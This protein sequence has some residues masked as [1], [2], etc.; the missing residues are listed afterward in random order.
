[1]ALYEML[2]SGVTTYVD[3]SPMRPNWITEIDAIGIRAC[4]APQY[5]SAFWYT[6]NG[7]EVLYEWDE[8]A[9]QRTFEEAL[10]LLDDVRKQ[11]STRITGM[12]APG[13]IDTCTPELI[14]ASRNAA[15]ERG[16]PWQIHAAQSVVEFREMFRRHGKTPIAWLDHLG[17][18]GPE[19][20]IGHCIF[21]DHHTWINWPDRDDLDRVARSGASV[22][23]C[24]N[25]FV[26]GG[27]LLE[28]F[29]VYR[30]RGINL[31]LGTDTHPHNFIDEMRWANALCKV[32]ARDVDAASVGD[33]FHAGTVGGAK[34]LHRDDLGRLAVG[35]KSDVVLVDLKHPYLQP[36]RDPLRTLVFS[37]Q[38]RAVCDVYVDG[39]QLVRD[40][41]VLT[42]DIE[43]VTEQINAGQRRALAGVPE[44]DWAKRTADEAFPLS[45][46]LG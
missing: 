28:N 35:C 18:L 14:I 8:A 41:K 42:I 13:Q 40:G 12:V 32:A 27:V 25:N 31:G 34:A 23:H 4:L 26:R 44:R 39:R 21:C 36:V 29:G 46:P 45:L 37:A 2:K 15:V 22:A 38:D 20:I 19:L 43:E 24:P 33:V 11:S 10:R 30:K 7:H 9:G 6:P 17:V 5:R 3:Y 1:M 16:I